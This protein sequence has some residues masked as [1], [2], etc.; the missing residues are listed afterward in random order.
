M[1]YARLSL[2][3]DSLFYERAVIL[4]EIFISEEVAAASAVARR[5]IRRR[6]ARINLRFS[7]LCMLRFIIILK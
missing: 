1:I 5:C 6:R 3:A 7:S 4:I 2:R